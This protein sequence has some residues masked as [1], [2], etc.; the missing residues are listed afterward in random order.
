MT[1]LLAKLGFRS[2]RGSAFADVIPV[3]PAEPGRQ[4][5]AP[6]ITNRTLQDA[7]AQEDHEMNEHI[8]KSYEDELAL[9][10]RKI[11]QMGG[12][13]EQLLAQSFQALEKRDPRLAGQVVAADRA[14]D[15]LEREIEEQVVMMIG[16][17]QPV[18]NDLRH[19]MAALRITGD[20]ERIGDLA[21]NIAKRALAVANESHPKPLITGLRHML[22]LAL[23]QL[24]QVLDAYAERDADRAMAV[25]RDDEQIDAMYNSLFR[26]LLT[27]MME[28]PRNIGLS[29]HLLFGAKNI[30]RVGDHTTNIAET[31]HYLVRGSLITDERPKSDETSSTMFQAG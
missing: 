9:L 20:L 14:V 10:D 21:K 26:E 5:G 6:G 16:R 7:T 13:T 3:R 23:R 1:G 28:D 31:I 2:V 29:T 4:P 25:W 17:R 30:E 24:K 22:D 12:L 11:A 27:Y 19:V 15:Q 18:A 8:V